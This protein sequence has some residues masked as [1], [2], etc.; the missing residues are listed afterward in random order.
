MKSLN[1]LISSQLQAK[2]L[3]IPL[4]TERVKMVLLYVL[5]QNIIVRLHI[6]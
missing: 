1:I 3:V 5:Q 2:H 6:I 4:Q